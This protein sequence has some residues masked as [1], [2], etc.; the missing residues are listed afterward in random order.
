MCAIATRARFLPLA[1]SRQK[2]S[3]RKQPFVFEAAHAHSTSVVR[4]H[5]FPR[6]ILAGLALPPVQLFPGQTPAQELSHIGT[7]LGQDAGGPV[8][9]D[10]GNRLQQFER[11]PK[12]R[13]FH[14]QK[15]LGVNLL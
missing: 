2:R 4:S 15:D 1:A 10:T 14:A 12:F 5:R 11:L 9:L 7:D 8:L 6:G 3:L 13:L